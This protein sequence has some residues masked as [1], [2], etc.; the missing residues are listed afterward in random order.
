MDGSPNPDTEID[1]VLMDIMMPEVDGIEA[2]RCINAV[3]GFR[4]IPIIMVTAR[5][6]AKYL[7]AAFSAGAS[8]SYRLYHQAS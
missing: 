3:E 5:A 8:L 7:E 2:C 1:L 4:D 6:D